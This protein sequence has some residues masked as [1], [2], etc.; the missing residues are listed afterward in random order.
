M[1][2]NFYIFG[3]GISFSVSPAIH[4]AGFQHYGLPFTY[5]IHESESI[6][7][8][9]ALIASDSFG[10]ASVTMPHKLEIHKFCNKKSESAQLI[11]AI[12]TLIVN[13]NG[14]DRII[15]GDNTD[16]SGLYSLMTAHSTKTQIQPRTGLVI[17]AGG[18]SR[19]AL[20]ALHKAGVKRIYLVN[21]TLATAKKVRDNFKTVFE[22]KVVTSLQDLPEKPEVVIGTV[23]AETTTED[24]FSS[25]FGD[26]GLCVDMSY[27]PRQT[28]LLTAAQQN[29]GWD[30]VTGMEVLLAQAF[31]QFLLWTGLEPPKEI[32]AGVISALD[33][34]RATA[35]K[36]GVL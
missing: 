18:A 10:G 33:G 32:M 6:D 29:L 31:D 1:V 11:G 36:G 3:K 26:R 14:S 34:E 25:M 2:K 15:S 24:Q 22:I 17:G 21:R 28:P 12:N 5:A 16:W 30:T 9:T 8:A 27:K 7:E 13:G 4:N 20:Y 19:A 35:A 23:P